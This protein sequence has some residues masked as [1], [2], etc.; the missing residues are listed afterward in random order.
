MRALQTSF[1]GASAKLGKLFRAT[2]QRRASTRSVSR[3]PN[4]RV[5]SR[6]SASPV[7]HGE[8]NLVEQAITGNSD[9]QEQL[10]KTFTPRLFRTAFAVLGNKQ[11]AEDAVQESWYKA[12]SN[13]D[14]FEGRSAFST[15]LTRILI[16]SALM[17]R[18]SKKIR[19]EASLDEILDGEFVSMLDRTAD[20][21]PNPEQFW[22]GNEL[23]VLIEAHLRQLL[24]GMQA[25][26]RLREVQGFSTTEIA[27]ALG[28]HKSALKSRI[29]RARHRLAVALQQ[30]ILK[31]ARLQA[32]LRGSVCP[33]NPSH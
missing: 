29:S 12:Y 20:E 11:D 33:R 22:P 31:P 13:F 26:F 8:W 2:R 19:K 21:R 27:E 32:A 25:A 14:S 17:R 4:S 24:A 6:G 1:G 23:N 15:W 5:F 3:A 10:F 28:I 16:N 18:R 30:T 9:A 7:V